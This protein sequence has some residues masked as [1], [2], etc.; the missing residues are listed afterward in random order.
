MNGEE[1]PDGPPV[2]YGAVSIY[3]RQMIPAMRH[4]PGWLHRLLNT[5]AV[6]RFAAKK[7]GST[8]AHGLEGL[9]ESMLLG[10]EGYQREDL[11]EITQYLKNIAKPD[12]VHF[13]NALLLG[14]AG[15]I[16]REV[17]VPVVCSL[18]DEDVWIDAM[19]PSYRT[20]MWELMASRANGTDALIAVSDWFASEMKQKMHLRQ[21]LVHTIPIGIQTNLYRINE[22]SLHERTIGY[23]S[24]LCDENGLSVLVDAFILLK[25]EAGFDDVKLRLTGG[26]TRDDHSFIRRQMKK[27]DEAGLSN[28]VEIREDFSMPALQDFFSGLTLLTVPV[29]KGE[30]FGMYQLE[31]MASG[32]PV[33]QPALGAFPE[34]AGKTGGGLI[35]KPNT[36]EALANAIVCLLNDPGKLLALGQAGRKGVMEHFEASLVTEK[37][38]SLYQQLIL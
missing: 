14:M 22:P 34:I 23:L 5:K 16:R 36:P 10:E 15:M 28:M 9:T 35:Y 37:L 31:A 21:G 12:I 24:R 27:T 2:F 38:M 30:A 26:K 7:S 11:A 32:I 3:L 6:L 13:S 4:M 19:E 8:R 29:L 33:V 20:K 17:G 18:Q 25:K 1:V